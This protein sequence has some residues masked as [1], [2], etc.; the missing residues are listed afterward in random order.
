M[1]RRTRQAIWSTLICA[2]LVLIAGAAV[3]Q[4]QA[5][6]VCSTSG[7]L[8]CVSVTAT[9]ENPA[10]SRD[11]L[12]TYISYQVVVSNQG[13][14]TITHAALAASLPTGS[15]FDS[16]TPNLGSCTG[17]GISASC[18]FG[19]VAAGASRTV[20]VVVQTPSSEGDAVATFAVSFDERFSDGGGSDPKQ[21]T[22]TVSETVGVVATADIAATFVPKGASVE[23]STDP[24][25]TGVATNEDQ[26][27]AT[28]AITSS[29]VSTSALLEEVPGPL[30]CPRRVVCRGGDWV[31]ATIPGTFDPPLA[32]GL[33]W[34]ATLIPSGLTAK[35][36]AVLV[37]ECLNGCPLE[38]VSDRCSS[39]TPGASELPCLRNVARLSDGD[40][41]ATLLNSHNGYMR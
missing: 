3:S 11:G 12:P 16:A 32:F 18:Q 27:T 2:S 22:V 9:P 38:V 33:R 36:F 19:S 14:N 10:P 6:E 1:P 8:V 23:I 4:A 17:S 21:D 15:S 29:P 35:K 26:Q 40:W 28:A 37:T 39:A 31:Q 20:E 34:N 13:R 25:G 41:I 7:P 30:S 5:T 24:T